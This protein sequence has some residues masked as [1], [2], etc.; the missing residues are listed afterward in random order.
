MADYLLERIIKMSRGLRSRKLWVFLITVL[1]SFVDR[2]ANLGLPMTAI[3]AVAGT[4]I[5]GESTIDSF[6]TNGKK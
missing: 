1:V 5:A 4:Y 6:S 2:V 3:S